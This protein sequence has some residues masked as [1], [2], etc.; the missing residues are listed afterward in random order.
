MRAPLLRSSLLLLTLALVTACGGKDEKAEAEAAAASSAL[1]VSLATVQQQTMARTVLVS[2][3]VSAYEEMQLGVEI[4]GQRVTALPV[5]VGQWVKQGQVL[6]QLDHRTLDSELAQADASLKQAQAAQD[7]ARMNY[8]RSAKLAAQQLISESSLDELR[9]NRI[10]AEAQTATARAAR[11]AAKLRRDFADLRAP[12]DGLISKRL[13]Q[14]GQVVSGGT[15]L[16]RLIRDGRLEWRAELPEDQL[17]GV[18]VGNTVELPYAGAV[19][20]GRIRAVTPGVDAQTRTGTLYADLPEPGTLKPGVYV[21]GRIVTGEGPVLTLPTAAIVQ[22]DGH[23][24][25]FTVN[26]KQQAARLRVRTGQAVQGRT[27]ILEGVKAG[28]RVVVDGAGFLGEGDRVR[29]VADAKAA[30]K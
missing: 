12:A 13:V 29:V 15:E 7:L 20:T 10:N 3:P 24:Y 25:V 23:S 14:P 4:S 21:E 8:E 27:A 30:A 17:T 6:L 18:A 1:P 16:L 22:R 19:V 5:D 2:G 28:D 11:D 9:A 26:D